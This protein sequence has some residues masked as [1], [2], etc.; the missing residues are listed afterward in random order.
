MMKQLV[1]R[2]DFMWRVEPKDALAS[3][4]DVILV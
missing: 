4:S 3:V 2:Y 1:M